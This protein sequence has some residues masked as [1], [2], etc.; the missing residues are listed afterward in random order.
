MFPSEDTSA[1]KSLQNTCDFGSYN[2]KDKGQDLHCILLSFS[3][4]K[5]NRILRNATAG[6]GIFSTP[7]L[8]FY[9]GQLAAWGA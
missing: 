2:L 8:S 3:K 1:L 5:Q 4:R 6:L 7:P 9:M